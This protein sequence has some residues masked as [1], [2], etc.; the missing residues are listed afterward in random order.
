MSKQPII[1]KRVEDEAHEG[2]HGGGWKVA[3]AD[4]MTAMMAFFLL[5][6]ILAAS[7]EEKLRGL[8]DYFTP[9]LSD[10][11]G[12]GEGF[13]DGIVLA[14]EGVMSGTDG[15]QSEVQL[16]SFGAENPLA[17]FDSRLRGQSQGIV[18]EYDEGEAAAEGVALVQTDPEGQAEGQRHAEQREADL[19]QIEAE[20]I[21]EIEAHPEYDNLA[22]NL[23]LE[24]TPDGLDIQIVDRDGRSMFESGSAA[25]GDRTR[26]LIEIIAH[27]VEGL[28][29]PLDISGHTDAV[30]FLRRSG[31]GNWELSSDRANAT[32]RIMVAAGVAQPRIS[33]IAGLAATVPLNAE[34]PE[35]AEN[36]R[37]S[38]LLRY[39]ETPKIT[40]AS[41]QVQP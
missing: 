13:L 24:R 21:R 4:F 36:R 35:A 19:A 1:I 27:A 25:I 6:W 32:R 11:G 40:E 16:P 39:P 33:R 37:I 29:Q 3:Y 2:H 17:V 9:S 7:D 14:N 20:I 26:G 28:T 8:A 38:I 41:G 23:R 18:I 30:P 5:L 22:D 31:Y 34:D 15:P 12:R 10:A